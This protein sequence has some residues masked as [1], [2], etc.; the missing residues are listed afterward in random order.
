[1]IVLDHLFSF[2]NEL[3]LHAEGDVPLPSVDTLI[4]I[5][6]SSIMKLPPGI[7]ES[8]FMAGVRNTQVLSGYDAHYESLYGTSFASLGEESIQSVQDI[9]DSVSSFIASVLIGESTNVTVSA[10]YLQDLLHCLAID[11]K[12]AIIEQS[13]GLKENEITNSLRWGMRAESWVD[14][15]PIDKY[16]GTYFVNAT[17][18]SHSQEGRQPYLL[19]NKKSKSVNYTG[20]PESICFSCRCCFTASRSVLFSLAPRIFRP[21]RVVALLPPERHGAKVRFLEGLQGNGQRILHQ[22]QVLCVERILPRRV[23]YGTDPSLR[24]SELIHSD[25]AG[26]V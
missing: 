22:G 13:L 7:G 2:S 17:L 12:C 18:W 21:Q 24:I 15:Q 16:A 4:P 8:F 23:R 1:M 3:F 20:S 19:I 11:G 26:R 25:G 9:A 5:Q 6:M 14:G 10:E